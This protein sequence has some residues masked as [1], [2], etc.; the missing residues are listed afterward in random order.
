M[1]FDRLKLL[2]GDKLELLNN[3]SV[4]ILGLG[5]VG[6]YATEVLAR[7]GIGHFV[8]I[9]SDTVDITNLN[10]QVVSN[11]NNIGA[12]KV[13]E[14]EKR[15]KSINPSANVIKIN[16]FIEA[17]NINDLLKYEF[18]YAIDACDTIS[19]KKEFIKLCL[20]NNIKFI[21]CMGTGKKFKPELLEITDL[22]KTNYDPIAKVLRQMIRREKIIGKI[23]VLYSKEIP[24]K[25]DDK[26]IGS[27]AFVPS[28][29]G[30][31]CGKYIF[32]LIVGDDV[33][34]SN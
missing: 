11:M 25:I 21:S 8:L 16:S 33:E 12:F 19:T 15:I 24:Q 29:A 32:D 22:S 23:P 18:D 28:V 3:S 6:G 31:M 9:D 14:W 10:R 7:S 4:L 2:I 1:Q 13:D 30:I 5:G 27:N 26:T 34:K 17:N 20:N